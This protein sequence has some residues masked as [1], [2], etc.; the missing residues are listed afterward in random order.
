M[1]DIGRRR[2][3]NADA[4]LVDSTADFYGVADGMGDGPRAGIVAKMALEAV[5]ELFLA[6]WSEIPRTL[7]RPEEATERLMLGVMQANTRLY[8]P[9]RPRERRLG[10]TLAAAVVCGDVVCVAHVGDSRIGVVRR[11]DG[12]LHHLTVDHTVLAEA[13]GLNADPRLAEA[14]PN[15][16]ALT[17]VLGG[18]P[19][20]QPTL[21][22]ARWEP[23]DVLILCTDGVTDLVDNG[24]IER[25][26]A[27]SVGLQQA[28]QRLVDCSNEA[29][30]RDNASV[31]LV[32][33]RGGTNEYRGAEG[34]A[35]AGASRN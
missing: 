35:G 26:L 17:R 2:Q 10:T 25:I 5:R 1:S 33:R 27:E 15:A 23:G 19:S 7:R 29:G 16:M 34:S 12:R 6:P 11:R 18:K 4:V 31:V 20:V 9:G 21:G 3:A 32:R 22:R 28:A 14:V 8:I 13:H 24:T 30:G